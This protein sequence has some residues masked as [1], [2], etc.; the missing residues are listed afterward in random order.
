[1]KSK[2]GA[3]FRLKARTNYPCLINTY[4]VRGKT[5]VPAQGF[6]A[7]CAAAQLRRNIDCKQS[8][9]FRQ[10][11]RVQFRQ[12]ELGWFVANSMMKLKKVYEK[13]IQLLQFLTS[14]K[15]CTLCFVL[16]CAG[17]SGCPIFPNFGIFWNCFK[18]KIL[19]NLGF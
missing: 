8:L 6:E 14:G 7:I 17:Q 10:S 12:K 9:I 3:C 16:W 2:L 13:L 19:S 4:A 15:H 18:F 11:L 5:E 1:M